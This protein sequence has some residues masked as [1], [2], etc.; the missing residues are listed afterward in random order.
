MRTKDELTLYRSWSEL[1]ISGSMTCISSSILLSITI[2]E[3]LLKES[4]QN[5]GLAPESHNYLTQNTD[6]NL[7]S[8]K[9]GQ[10]N[11]ALSTEIFPTF[12]L[13]PESA[14]SKGPFTQAIFVAAIFVAPKL[15]RQNRT[16]KPA[17]ISVRF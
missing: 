12:C 15:Q 10:T 2:P 9:F 14:L 7:I 6:L 11:L 16:C 13:V 4:K 8:P 1:C 5:S 3:D 17:A